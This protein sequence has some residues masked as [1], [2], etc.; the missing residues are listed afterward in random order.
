MLFSAIASQCPLEWYFSNDQRYAI[1]LND[2]AIVK[3]FELIGV[4]IVSICCAL[5]TSVGGN[6]TLIDLF[7]R[8][9]KSW[10]NTVD[11]FPRTENAHKNHYRTG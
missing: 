8:T 2:L 4:C 3:R 7:P 10:N 11:M 6:L 9:D 1:M 5:A